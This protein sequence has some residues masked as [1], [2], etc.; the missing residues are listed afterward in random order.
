MEI[1]K[2]PDVQNSQAARAIKTDE[3]QMSIGEQ[4][5]SMAGVSTQKNLYG[6]PKN[7]MGKDAF[8]RLFMEQLKYQDPMNPVKNDQFGQQMA[9][10]SQLEQQ[11]NMNKT[12]EKLVSGQSNQ[13]VAALQLVGKEI[14]ADR[15]ALYH[16]KSKHT[17]MTFKLPMDVNELKIEI[18]DPAGEVVKTYALGAR[19]QGDM[20]W[21]WDGFNE[22]GAPVESGRYSYRVAGK[23]LDGTEVKVNTKVDGRVTGVTSAQGVV[24]L[25]VGDQKIGLS[26]VETIKESQNANTQAAS[27]A[28]GL[29]APGSAAA[30]PAGGGVVPQQ[31]AAP[32]NPTA[33]KTDAGTESESTLEKAKSFDSPLSEDRLRMMLPLY[34]R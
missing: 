25:L 27:T 29:A 2:G 22:A 33:A 19:E 9:A 23:G 18:V 21:K 12:L 3:R 14:T 8:L 30:S 4:L 28:P 20:T 5:N 1:S 32:T 13:Q 24:F 31:V 10:F 11:M 15:G 6:E 16:E 26:D 34:L 7:V 17:A